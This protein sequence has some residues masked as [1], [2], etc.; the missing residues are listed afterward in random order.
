M[1]HCHLI[2]I[3]GSDA[4]S[5]TS[6]MSWPLVFKND[7][8]FFSWSHVIFDLSKIAHLIQGQKCLRCF[9]EIKSLSKVLQKTASFLKHYDFSEML[10]LIERGFWRHMILCDAKCSYYEYKNQTKYHFYR[11]NFQVSDPLVRV[12][13]NFLE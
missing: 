10:Y 12:N 4:G 13:A 3:R 9:F 2:W 1:F 7:A 6:D 5:K 8:A 11:S